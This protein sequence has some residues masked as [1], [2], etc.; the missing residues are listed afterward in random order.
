[1]KGFSSLKKPPEEKAKVENI[2]I[3]AIQ[4][5]KLVPMTMNVH[6]YGVVKPK[7]ETELVTQVSGKIVE[8]SAAFVRGGFIKKNQLLA[9]IDPSDYKAALMDAQANLASAQAALSK[10]L[11]QGKVA[12]KEWKHI[13]ST[14]PT[15]LSLRK[16]QLAQEVARVKAAKAGVLRAKRAMDRTEIRAPY[17]AMIANRNIGLGSFVSVGSNIGKLLGTAIAEVRL[18]VA[19]NQLSYLVK[20]GLNSHVNLSGQFAGKQ[21][22]WSA[23][24]VRNEGVI[25]AKSRMNYLV[26][27]IDDPYLLSQ[28]SKKKILKPLR[29]GAYVDADIK[30]QPIANA[31]VIPRYLVVNKKVAT[32]DDDSKL[33]Y[34]TVHIVREQAANVVISSG[35]NNGDQ[36]IVSTLEYPID[37]MKLALINNT[38]KLKDTITPKDDKTKATQVAK[39]ED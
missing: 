17:N 33:H 6:S 35:L 4:K 37:G 12:A 3:V 9:K 29:F 31:T 2:P 23:H 7:Y 16:P 26:A 14:A 21:V 25:D 38:P 18:P 20:Q 36:L 27:Q 30:G 32:L 13:T 1:M 11:A 24:I 15:K 28:S 39:L 5:I 8:L 34:V 10:E 22:Q 19:D